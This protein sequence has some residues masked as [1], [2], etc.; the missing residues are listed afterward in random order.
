MNNVLM[1]CG[2]IANAKYNDGEPCCLICAPK[3][4]AFEVVEE[5]PDLKKRK[6]KCTGCGKITDSRLDLPFF[7]YRPDKE[8]DHYYDG[9]HGWD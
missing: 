3:R 1:K 4:E 7:A 2:H 6:A 5:K 8:F 9:C